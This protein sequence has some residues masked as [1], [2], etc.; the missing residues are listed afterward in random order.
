[1]KKLLLTITL[2]LAAFATAH[3]QYSPYGAIE[4]FYQANPDLNTGQ[5]A[6]RAV[7][8]AYWL[9]NWSRWEEMD[10]RLTG[11]GFIR[12]GVSSFEGDNASGAGVPQR[13][14][15]MAHARAIG[16]DVV[17]YAVHAATEK[18]DW[19]AHDV[20]FYAKQSV[21]RATSASNGRRP[22]GAEATAAIN[23]AQDAWHEPRVK[24]GVW[25]DPK[26]D[27]YNWIGPSG[28][29]RSKSASWFL[30]KFGSYL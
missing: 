25:Y 19:T 11:D 20:A 3:A 22:T 21:P 26:T 4:N 18:Y 8:P 5:Y 12:L 9:V 10:S 29:P 6:S 1:M 2:G 24:G 16:A 15:A 7:H 28:Q 13:D 17:I 14:L 23:R 27:T 30:N